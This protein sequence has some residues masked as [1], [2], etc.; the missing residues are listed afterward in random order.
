MVGS[1]YKMFTNGEFAF[2]GHAS[3]KFMLIPSVLHPESR[4]R[5]NQFALNREMT[6]QK[7]S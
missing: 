3:E 1:K 5:F 7:K 4:K 2:R 6:G